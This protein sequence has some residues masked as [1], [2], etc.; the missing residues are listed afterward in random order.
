MMRF[1][2][3]AALV[4]GMVLTALLPALN[5]PMAGPADVHGQEVTASVSFERVVPL[6]FEAS[7][8]ALHW[9]GA[10]DAQVRIAFGEDATSFGDEIDVALDDDAD[11]APGEVFSG[12]LWTGGARYARLTTDRTIDALK[13]LAI[14][15]GQR[16]PGGTADGEAGGIG[17]GA[18]ADAAVSM[19]PIISRHDWGAN[20]SYRFNSGGY[21]IFPSTYYPL[22]KVIVHHTAS[23]ND[24]PDPEATIRAIYYMHAVSRG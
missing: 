21:E 8:V 23:R 10:P 7:H 19:P 6:P 16:T 20:E 3:V 1:R 15:A 4:T 13:V 22:Q 12:V 2:L 17:L 14:D 9:T 5:L 18:V 11:G 24:D